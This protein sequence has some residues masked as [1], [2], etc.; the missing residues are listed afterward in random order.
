MAAPKSIKDFRTCGCKPFRRQLLIRG[1]EVRTTVMVQLLVFIS[2]SNQSFGKFISCLLF[3]SVFDV[4]IVR[5]H[6][7]CLQLGI[8][9]YVGCL[10]EWAML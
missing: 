8:S 2:S 9:G 10:P 3:Q 1:I 7:G 6:R 5:C 4:N